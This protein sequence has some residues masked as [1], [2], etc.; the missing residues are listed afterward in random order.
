M[1][2]Y[3]QPTLREMAAH[4]RLHINK[5]GVPMKN[6][7]EKLARSIISLASLN[8]KGTVSKR[9]H[10]KASSKE[11]QLL[12]NLSK[13]TETISN[14]ANWQLILNTWLVIILIMIPK[15]S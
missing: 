5:N 12:C 6:Y 13:S 11:G 8:K 15:Q 3:V 9:K 1:E 10:F 4:I 7:T 14:I 2:E